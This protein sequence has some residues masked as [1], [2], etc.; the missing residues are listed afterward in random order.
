MM[1][2]AEVPSEG[3]SESGAPWQTLCATEIIQAC[4]SVGNDVASGSAFEGTVQV[5]LCRN[6]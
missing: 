1:S 3:L 6:E 2:A 5:I 4:C